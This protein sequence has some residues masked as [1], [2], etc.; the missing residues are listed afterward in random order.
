MAD[1]DIIVSLD[2]VIPYISMLALTLKAFLSAVKNEYSN[3]FLQT[4]N[5]FTKFMLFEYKNYSKLQSNYEPLWK[6]IWHE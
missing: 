2:L 1:S 6:I 5:M 4:K 3:K